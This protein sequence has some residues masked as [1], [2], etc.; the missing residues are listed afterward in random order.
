MSIPSTDRVRSVLL[1]A[2]T[3]TGLTITT[4]LPD[5][6][7]CLLTG[8]KWVNSVSMELML[9]LLQLL[10]ISSAAGCGGSEEGR[11]GLNREEWWKLIEQ[12][13]AFIF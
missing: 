6:R 2:L 10:D 11:G 7:G 1:V 8:L 9:S 13:F 5:V 3:G 4:C 12:G